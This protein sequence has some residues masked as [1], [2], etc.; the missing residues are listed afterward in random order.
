[1][2]TTGEAGPVLTPAQQ[3]VADRVITALAGPDAR[4]RPDQQTA[5]AALASPGS[6]A[7]V[8][9]ATGWGK[10]A[11]YWAATAVIRAAGG[12][13][14]LIVSPLL[15]LMRDQVSAAGRGGLRAATLNSSNVDEW[16]SIE[17]DLAAGHLDV[18]LVSP[19]RLA[20]P[21]FGR[22]VLDALAG[23]LG[24]V[25]IDE[26]H[27]I[28]DWGHDFRPDYRRVAQ[29]LQQLNPQTSVLA[30]TA[31]ANERVTED[32]A[33]QLGAATLVLRGPLARKSLHLN[34]IDGL[35]P[36]ERYGWVAEQL[37][38]LPGSG[39]VYVLTVADADRLVTAIKALHGDDY[40]VA[41]YTGQLPADDRHRLEDDLLANRVK[42]LVATSALG[43]GFDKPDLGFVVH[44]G[45]P[46]SPVSYYQQ[47]GRAGRALDEAVVVLL[48]SAMDESVWEYFATATIPDAQRMERLLDA[49]AETDGPA[50]VPQ[51]E[52]RTGLR[53][54]RVELMVKQ[55]AVDGAVDRV[56]DGWVRTGAPW[57]Y[58]AEHYDGVLAV[59]RREADIMRAY[60][61]G[62]ACLMKLLTQALDDPLA[63]DCGRCS[64][65]L[66]ALTPGLAATVPASLLHTVSA[67]LR[68]QAQVLEPRKMWPG[69]VFGTRGRIP[70]GLLAE[71]GR[72]LAFA[73][74]PQWSDTLA[75]ARSGDAQAR[76]ELLQAAVAVLAD[77]GRAGIRPDLIVGLDLGT[78][79]ATDL[80]AQLRA[81]GRRSGYDYPVPAGPGPGREVNGPTEAAYWRD[82]L[83]PPPAEAADHPGASVL[84]VIDQTSSTWPVA[85]AAA[86]LQEAGAGPVLPLLIHQTV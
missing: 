33:G 37:P 85:L 35:S 39:I 51:L 84:L 24:L 83:G 72:V 30:T 68:R 65:C 47:V 17:Q 40:P 59:R 76:E 61:G 12:G 18:L 10:S 15:S 71:P 81:V 43:M 3:Q 80:A 31:T 57:T 66:A 46:P 86:A 7:L 20:N 28:S 64:V 77:W 74:A 78:G 36:I 2:T 38:A 1:M 56:P 23:N 54:T 52:A 55:L 48:A 11:V 45:A 50:T 63:Q 13:P 82:R 14:T 44:V 42:A 73:E 6:R 22:R 5:V 8:V 58:D 75:A 49:L 32:I 16:T 67:A 60:I 27:A 70:P 21:G 29:V 4:L 62:R 19:E 53:R 69:G 25:V 41:A 26:A 34:V 79:L 9:Q